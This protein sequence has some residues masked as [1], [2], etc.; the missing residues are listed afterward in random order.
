VI[1]LT[2]PFPLSFNRLYKPVI[3]SGVAT[4]K[5][6]TEARSYAKDCWKAILKQGFR[7]TKKRKVPAGPLV[8]DITYYLPDLQMRDLDNLQKIIL[9]VVSEALGFNDAEVIEL[10]LKKTLAR[11]RPRCEVL[12]WGSDTVVITPEIVERKEGAHA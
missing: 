7:A 10:H 4:L 6:T 1:A 2:L 3:V 5:K 8:M 9:D 11:G 12:I